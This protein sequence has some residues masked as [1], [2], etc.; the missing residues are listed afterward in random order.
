MSF[1]SSQQDHQEYR[2][3]TITATGSLNSEVHLD[4]LYNGLNQFIE[5][6]SKDPMF[7]DVI[8]IEYG[9]KKRDMGHVK[10]FINRQNRMSEMSV[11]TKRFDNQVTIVYRILLNDMI[12]MLNTKIFKNGNIQ[13]T[14]IR[15]IQQGSFMIDKIITIIHYMQKKGIECVPDIE[16]VLQKKY[17]LRL[18]NS[19]FKIG[20]QIRREL[21]HKLL[22]EE[23]GVNCSFEPCIYP[24]VKIKYYFNTQNCLKNGVCYCSQKCLI[25]K[26]SGMED[27]EC[28][29]VTIA[30]FQSGCVIITGGQTM[31]QL[32]EAYRFIRKVLN[33]NSDKKK[34]VPLQVIEKKPQVKYI[35]KIS[36]IQK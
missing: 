34:N 7:A 17:L 10:K 8:Y 25:G 26:S 1:I 12:C 32:N 4:S 30:V 23:C 21:L 22:V 20:F 15:N 31:D 28:K 24:A 19:D 33:E 13:M 9:K 29:K 14:G 5:N 18:I 3:S 11:N 27:K 16:H 2:I 36:N 6:E 35:I